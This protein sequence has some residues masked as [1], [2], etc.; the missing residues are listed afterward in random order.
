MNEKIFYIMYL[1]TQ[2]TIFTQLNY[3]HS[4][5]VCLP[6]I[7]QF[8]EYAGIIRGFLTKEKTCRF[9]KQ[10]VDIQV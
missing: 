6:D 2:F 3:F 9:F 5:E 1:K 7:F 8:T 10:I 4:G